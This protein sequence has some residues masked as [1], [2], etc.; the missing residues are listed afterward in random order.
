[1][2]RWGVLGARQGKVRQGTRRGQL[3]TKLATCTALHPRGFD[4]ELYIEKLF[5]HGEFE[6]RKDAKMVIFHSTIDCFSMVSFFHCHYHPFV[7]V[8]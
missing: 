7:C 3:N 1:M 5:S 8:P 2:V 4:S 6:M